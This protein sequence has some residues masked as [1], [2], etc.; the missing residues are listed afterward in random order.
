VWF[1][2]ACCGPSGNTRSTRTRLNAIIPSMRPL[3]AFSEISQPT[4]F[5]TGLVLASWLGAS[6]CDFGENLGKLCPDRA[7][8]HVRQC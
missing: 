4:I 2:R 6:V 7:S 5:V 8:L 1:V 3:P